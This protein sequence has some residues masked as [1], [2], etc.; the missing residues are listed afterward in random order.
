MLNKVNMEYMR[1]LG[2]YF[3]ERDI[4]YVMCVGNLPNAYTWHSYVYSRSSLT[5]RFGK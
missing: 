2:L 4:N 3:L 1:N 5:M